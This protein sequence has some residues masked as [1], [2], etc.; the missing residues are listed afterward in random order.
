MVP[1]QGKALTSRSLCY[2]RVRVWD[3]KKQASSLNTGV[4]GRDILLG[5]G[6]AHNGVDE[7]VTLAGLVGLDL[8]LNMTVLAL[9]T[10][11]TCVLGLLVGAFVQHSV[12]VSKKS[13]SLI[14]TSILPFSNRKYN[15][16]KKCV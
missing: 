15:H 10:G 5:D 12:C 6:A 8:D 11:L 13:T 2:W 3:A 4:D 1:Y 14:D 9:T 7:L 16:Q